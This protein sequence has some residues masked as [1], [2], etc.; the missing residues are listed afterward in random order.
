MNINQHHNDDDLDIFRRHLGSDE[1]FYPGDSE[2]DDMIA[3]VDGAIDRDHKI[4]P[5]RRTWWKPVAVAAAAVVVFAIGL[6]S[7]RDGDHAVA[8]VALIDSID[9]QVGAV[10]MVDENTIPFND[11][12]LNSLMY[13]ASANAP[14]GAGERLLNDLTDEEF[15]YLNNHFDVGDIL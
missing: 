4:T 2:V 1:D 15:E 13:Q 14:F 6:I 8:P 3:A 12:E 10:A 9:A 11:D 7:F 5:V